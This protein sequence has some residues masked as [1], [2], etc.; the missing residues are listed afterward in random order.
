M[1]TQR[2]RGLTEQAAETA[3]DQACRLLRLPTVRAQ[4]TDIAEAASREQM[5]YRGFLAELLMAECDDRNRRRSEHRI[6]AAAFPRDKSLR[7]FDFDANPNIDPAAVHTLA[8]CDWVNKGQPLCLI[9]DSGTG[10]SHLLIALGTEAAIAGYRVR[11]T[12]ATKLVNELVEA[13]DEKSLNK[14]IAR[15]GRVDL[16]CIDELGYMELDRR[17]AELL[18][19][20]LTEREEK[21]SVAIASNESFGGWTKTFTDPRLCAAIVDRLTFGGTILETGTDSYR[22]AHT[23]NRTEHQA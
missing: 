23:R 12:L 8:R 10:K 6:K 21:A 4:F 13:A 16:L 15:Y 19:Q 22:L 1:T 17:G 7:A 11:Y 18:F 5:T 20:V 9:G 3:V 2:H 14:T